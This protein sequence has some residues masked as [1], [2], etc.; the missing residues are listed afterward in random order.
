MPSA[1]AARAGPPPGRDK[2]DRVSLQ[3]VKAVIKQRAGSAATRLGILARAHRGRVVVLAY[4]RV[5]P[6]D[7]LEAYA[8]E[9]GMYVTDAAFRRQMAFVRSHYDVL[10][11]RDWLASWAAGGP[12]PR[13]RYCLITFDDGWRDTFEV[14]F[15]I[16]REMRLPATVFLATG[17]IG[18]DDWF[19]TERVTYLLMRGDLRRLDGRAAAAPASSPWAALV[20][21]DRLNGEAAHRRRRAEQVSETLRRLKAH[22]VERLQA[23]S[24]ELADA[25]QTAPPRERACLTWDEARQMSVA[26]VTF[27]SHTASHRIL[28]GIPAGVVRDELERSQRTLA[29]Q[30]VAAVPVFCYPNGGFDLAV[31]RLVQAAGYRAACSTRSGVEPPVPADRFAVR[32]IS[33]HED[34]ACSDGLLG[35]R[36]L[37]PGR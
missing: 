19:W 5:L 6:G 11:M 29:A 21:L 12:D 8:A 25:L 16:L 4:H 30:A 10:S 17:F 18:T 24:G 9:P 36:L 33:L 3:A 13:G 35:L 37:L 23:F 1:A 27:G 26:G 14:A 22:P 32:R 7:R 28:P 15:P 34:V 2:A 31:Q 20:G